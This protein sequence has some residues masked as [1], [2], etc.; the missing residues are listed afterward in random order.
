[1]D[2]YCEII[3][4]KCADFKEA[5]SR[6]KDAKKLYKNIKFVGIINYLYLKDEQLEVKFMHKSFKS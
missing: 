6:W 1:M 3:S 5:I 4:V 2:Y